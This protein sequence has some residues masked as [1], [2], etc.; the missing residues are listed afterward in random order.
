[1][2][3]L[4]PVLGWCDY[5][6]IVD[7]TPGCFPFKELSPQVHVLQDG[8]NRGLGNAL[9][10]GMA[11]AKSLGAEAAVLFDQ[12]ST[13]TKENLMGL[14]GGLDACGDGRII[15]GP[16]LQDDQIPARAVQ[17]QGPGRPPVPITCMPTAGLAFRLA[18]LGEGDGFTEEL[19]LDFADFEWCFRLGASGWRIFQLPEVVL[20]H[21]IGGGERTFLGKRY[22]IPAPF[23]LYFQFRD[24]IRLVQLSYVPLYDKIRLAATLPLKM[25]FYPFLMDRGWERFKWILAGIRDSFRK[26][27][28]VGAAAEELL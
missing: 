21:R 19:F 2:S 16:V 17:K 3:R 6:V 26:I 8:V 28:G 13:P 7:N 12:D 4:E 24:L 9:N 18:G 23:R 11:L 25:A 22:N 5:V 1:M 27:K 14:F 20:L 10:R 15:V